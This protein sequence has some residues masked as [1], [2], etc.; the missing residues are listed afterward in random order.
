[1][2][3]QATEATVD[4]LFDGVM[5]PVEDPFHYPAYSV[6]G[7]RC[8]MCGWTVGARG[9]PRAHQCPEEGDRQGAAQEALGL[10]V[11]EKP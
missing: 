9:L 6:P 8:K 3:I 2:T 10:T 11:E 5:I 1:M 7:W 4:A